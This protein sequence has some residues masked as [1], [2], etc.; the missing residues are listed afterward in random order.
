MAAESK[1]ENAVIGYARGQGIL[2]YKFIS[3]ANRGVPD[4]V[5]LFP[6]GITLWIEFKAPGRKPSMMQAHTIAKMLKQKC[7]VAVVDDL[8]AAKDIIDRLMTMKQTLE[9]K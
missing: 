6:S 2:T 8:E 7:L 4:R 1:L 3:P 9:Q 5:F